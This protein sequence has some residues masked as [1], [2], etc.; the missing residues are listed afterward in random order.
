MVHFTGHVSA[1]QNNAVCYSEVVDSSTN[2]TTLTKATC[3]T[4]GLNVN[5]KTFTL[6]TN[7]CYYVDNNVQ[8]PSP[9]PDN[10]G[11]YATITAYEQ[12]SCT[13]LECQSGSIPSGTNCS[14]SD[15]CDPS[16]PNS[17]SALCSTI[18]QNYVNPIILFLGAGVGLVIIIM[19]IIGGIQYITS[20]GDPNHV[21]EAKKR[22]ANALL[23]LITW[24]LIYAF[25]NWIMPGGLSF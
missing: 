5:G 2:V 22:I 16:S 15:P 13:T 24:I 1:D 4:T 3:P 12:E 18:V 6:N 14:P 9:T 19:I 11:A 17:N 8:V 20:G 10:P 25:L 21:N 7:D 23:A